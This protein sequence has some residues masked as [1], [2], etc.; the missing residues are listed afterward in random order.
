M[1]N[2]TI[3]RKIDDLGRFVLPIDVRKK[4]NINQLLDPLKVKKIM[5]VDTNDDDCKTVLKGHIANHLISLSTRALKENPGLIKPIRKD[6]RKELRAMLP[7]IKG[8]SLKIK[9]LWAAY[10][11]TS[12]RWVH[13]IYLKITGLDKIYEIS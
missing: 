6:A 12:Y 8:K 10:L 1:D 3:I 5:F 9:A 7:K 11:P 13:N 2:T 4:L